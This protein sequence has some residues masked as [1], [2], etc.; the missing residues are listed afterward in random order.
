[1]YRSVSSPNVRSLVGYW[2]VAKGGEGGGLG[3]GK[4]GS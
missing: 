1:M 2:G 4:G 3:V